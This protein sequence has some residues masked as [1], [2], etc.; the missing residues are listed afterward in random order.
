MDWDN[1]LLIKMVHE[2]KGAEGFEESL[3]VKL[4]QILKD[5]LANLFEVINV[6]L[7]FKDFSLF[8]P[9]LVVRV[10]VLLKRDSYL[11]KDV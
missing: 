4:S 1:E 7:S 6:C 10:L 8:Q 2:S 11:S 9:V 5:K 3:S